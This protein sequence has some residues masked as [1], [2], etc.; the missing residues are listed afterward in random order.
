MKNKTSQIQSAE[1]DHLLGYYMLEGVFNDVFYYTQQTTRHNV[2]EDGDKGTQ[3][4][5]IPVG[6]Y[7]FQVRRIG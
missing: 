4:K 7:V 5:F 6:L 3:H 2:F 1:I